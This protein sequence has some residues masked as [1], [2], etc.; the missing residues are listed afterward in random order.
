MC[1]ATAVASVGAQSADSATAPNQRIE[2]ITH[3]D[4]G[5]R[6]DEVRVGGVT[7]QIEVQTKSGMPGY[8]IQPTTNTQGT[9]TSAGER[10]GSQGSAGRASWRLLNF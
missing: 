8:Q 6:V 10:S 5:S 4:A 9:V 3:E 7:R 2:R 1:C